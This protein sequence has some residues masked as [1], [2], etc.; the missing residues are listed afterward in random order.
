VPDRALWDQGY[1]AEA[2]RSLL[3]N[4]LTLDEALAVVRSFLNPLLDDTAAGVWNP[5][6]ASWTRS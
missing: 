6:T 3:D 5:D 1:R 4:A 2:N